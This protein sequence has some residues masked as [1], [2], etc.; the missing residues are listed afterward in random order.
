M[1]LAARFP[2]ILGGSTDLVPALHNLQEEQGCQLTLGV[3]EDQMFIVYFD[4]GSHNERFVV[5]RR[6]W[7]FARS[8]EPAIAEAFFIDSCPEISVR[9]L[10]TIKDKMFTNKRP[11]V[12][13][14]SHLVPQT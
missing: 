2:A 8:G 3:A 1:K 12:K 10:W 5:S 7:N 14:P 11:L 6:D 4:S 13:P 9:R